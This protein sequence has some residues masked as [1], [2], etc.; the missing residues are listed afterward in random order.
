MMMMDSK[1]RNGKNY[2]LVMESNSSG[3][4]GFFLESLGGAAKKGFLNR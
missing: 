4:G 1:H 2:F 3:S